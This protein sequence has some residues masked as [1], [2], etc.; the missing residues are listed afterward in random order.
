MTLIRLQTGFEK[1]QKEQTNAA[2]AIKSVQLEGVKKLE[3]ETAQGYFIFQGESELHTLF[4]TSPFNGVFK[5]YYDLEGKRWLS[6]KDDH[7]LEENLAR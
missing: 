6:N 2:S 4:Y 1:L 3:V 5:Y 7:I